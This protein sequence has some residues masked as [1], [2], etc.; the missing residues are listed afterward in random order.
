M[1]P[2]I[3][4]GYYFG[5]QVKLD[6]VRIKRISGVKRQRN[7]PTEVATEVVERI[8]QIKKCLKFCFKV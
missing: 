3:I 2:F 4:S 6:S 1:W 8:L 5:N 7:I